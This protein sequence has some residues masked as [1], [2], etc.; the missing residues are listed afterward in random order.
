[1]ASEK[2][3]LLPRQ[4]R[5]LTWLRPSKCYE[6]KN[7]VGRRAGTLLLCSLCLTN[8]WLSEGTRDPLKVLPTERLL[9]STPT[10]LPAPAAA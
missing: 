7:E 4:Q 9:P 6:V 1:M 8:S 5:V 10:L 2:R 3:C